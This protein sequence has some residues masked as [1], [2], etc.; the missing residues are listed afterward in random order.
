MGSAGEDLPPIGFNTFPSYLRS[1]LG[2]DFTAETHVYGCRLRVPRSYK[3]PFGVVL[4]APGDSKADLGGR[5]TVISTP[6]N[7]GM[8]LTMFHG[9][10]TRLG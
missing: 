3:V 6:A 8:L 10:S 7:T 5:S 9:G 4:P 2:F 1:H